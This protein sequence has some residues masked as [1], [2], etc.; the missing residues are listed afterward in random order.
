MLP[1]INDTGQDLGCDP[2]GLDLV[3]PLYEACSASVKQAPGYPIFAFPLPQ[4][5][6]LPS[7]SG[8]KL[9]L[10][11]CQLGKGIALDEE[12]LLYKVINSCFSD[13]ILNRRKGERLELVTSNGSE[14]PADPRAV[15]VLQEQLL[16]MLK[17]ELC[18]QKPSS[19][20]RQK[21]WLE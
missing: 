19:L 15:A 16:S 1:L 13:G 14:M 8:L 2:Q 9:W 7:C 20:P 11:H 12:N 18:S 6:P 21:F 10:S 3:M 5:A 4:G 17:P